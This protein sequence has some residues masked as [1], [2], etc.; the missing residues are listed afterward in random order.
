[1]CGQLPYTCYNVVGTAWALELSRVTS[2]RAKLFAVR[3]V[4]YRG[5]EIGS[6]AGGEGGRGEGPYPGPN[7][8]WLKATRF[9][10]S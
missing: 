9:A 1:M 6:P 7:E 3:G 8:R 4:W 5:L 2:E 10:H